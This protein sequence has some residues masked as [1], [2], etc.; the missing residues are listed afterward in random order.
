MLAAENFQKTYS[1]VFEPNIRRRSWDQAGHF[2]NGQVPP[3]DISPSTSPIPSPPLMPL[4][5]STTTTSMDA[6]ANSPVNHPTS[7][8]PFMC[9]SIPALS[10]LT[11][12][13][14][15]KTHSF[16]HRVSQSGKAC[17]QRYGVVASKAAGQAK[18]GMAELAV[19]A[20]EVY[21]QECRSS[22]SGSPSSQHHHGADDEFFV[23]VVH[24]HNGD[25][26]DNSL[27]MTTEDN[28]VI[29]E[30]R[31]TTNENPAPA[32]FQNINRHNNASSKPRTLAETP[33]SRGSTSSPPSDRVTPLPRL[34]KRIMHPRHEIPFPKESD[35]LRGRSPANVEEDDDS[36]VHHHHHLDP[37]RRGASMENLFL[38]QVAGIDH[39]E[40]RLAKALD[41]LN[42]QDT[43]IQSLKRQL[44]ETQNTLD[45]TSQEMSQVKAA[46]KEKQFKATEIRARAV[47]EKKRLEDL[48]HKE[49]QQNKQL[50]E[51]IS[52]LHVE[53]SILKT[54]LRNARSTTKGSILDNG[55]NAQIISL[56]AELVELRSQL[57]EA[58]AINI[59]DAS[60]RQSKG[61]IDELKKKS[62]KDE[63]EIN[64]LRQ[65][66]QEGLQ[67]RHNL[68]E[69]ERL[70]QEKLDS[71]QASSQETQ[72]RLEENLLIAMKSADDV[73]AELVK[74]K[75]NLQRME[76][77]RS[78]ARVH[79]FTDVDRVQKELSKS[80]EQCVSLKADLAN[81]RNTS[82]AECQE[83][84]KELEQLKEQ[85]EKANQENLARSKESMRELRKIQDEVSCHVTEIKD[86]KERLMEKD[87]ELASKS[88]TVAKL[89]ED[90]QMIKQEFQVGGNS[91]TRLSRDLEFSQS[92]Q[93][94]MSTEAILYKALLNEARLNPSAPQTQD[95]LLG[96]DTNAISEL[97]GHVEKF[98]ASTPNCDTMSLEASLKQEIFA[99]KSRLGASR[100]QTKAASLAATEQAFLN[101][102]SVL[103]AKLAESHTKIREETFRLHE[104]RRV[105]R[106]GEIER[107]A[108]MEMLEA[109][110]NEA[111]EGRKVLQSEVMTLRNTL[112]SLRSSD[113]PELIP[114]NSS[115]SSS[116]G[117]S[118]SKEE[119]VFGVPNNV[120]RLRSE[121]AQARERLAAA[122]ENSRS[123]PIRPTTS[124]GP[125]YEPSDW[126]R[127]PGNVPERADKAM[128][129][130]P[131]V[132]KGQ[133]YIARSQTVSSPSV[134]ESTT[135]GND[136]VASKAET[137]RVSNG[138]TKDLSLEELS[139]QL[140]ASRQ[141]L[142]TADQRLNCLVSNGS[143]LTIVR[144]SPLDSSFDGSIDEVVD[145]A[146]G[147]IEVNH[148]RFADV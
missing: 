20:S 143:L 88:R 105:N 80:N 53:V 107:H 24:V 132:I 17:R 60:S 25:S 93:M 148:R 37:S 140:E 82:K 92:K 96:L 104:E 18:A 11:L 120:R 57:A 110:R 115:C 145:T 131:T 42:R 39:P 22:S 40:V 66:N 77:E 75:A 91:V 125:H 83:L 29:L 122:R 103:K 3:L 26:A 129:T 112:L 138:R 76:R 28:S 67:E 74:T 111:V 141:R 119:D 108:D 47:Q 52:Q 16:T 44:Q 100:T 106:E 113:M 7:T 36:N 35:H 123:I 23:D 15:S 89:Q 73:R 84:T 43:L 136:F 98:Q 114:E 14:G 68:M 127:R 10:A 61:E 135:M 58:H 81:A 4:V 90:I 55:Q 62:R 71:L 137:P 45:D 64:D 12:T 33:S 117:S 102:I 65:R 72:S 8:N 50:Q 85:L 5:D 87:D 124:P 144:K 6:A 116:S 21:R 94:A 54:S 79:S 51:S 13:P 49:V 139:R 101:E 63:C 27:L 48:Y 97:K 109:E 46:A 56:K 30:Q 41:D 19:I 121:L 70:L 118:S 126:S 69:R 9:A 38:N 86:L 95:F 32:S 31:D 34:D 130:N 2:G 59:D 147:N 142:E 146:D 133:P 99:L 1:N 78:R 134:P 128:P